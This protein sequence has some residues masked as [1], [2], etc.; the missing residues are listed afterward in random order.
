[1]PRTLLR[2]TLHELA[3]L[4]LTLPAIQSYSYRHFT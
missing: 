1:M 3:H 4:I 2:T